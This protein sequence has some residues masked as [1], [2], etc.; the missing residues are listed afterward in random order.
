ME[1]FQGNFGGKAA[2]VSIVANYPSLQF[3]PALDCVLILTI[4]FPIVVLQYLS[5][6]LCVRLIVTEVLCIL[7]VS[8]FSFVTVINTDGDFGGKVE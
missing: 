4:N 7:F 6:S 5:S 3:L 8:T 1:L 2:K